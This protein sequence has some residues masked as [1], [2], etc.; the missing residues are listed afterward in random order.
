VGSNSDHELITETINQILEPI[1]RR[2][3][4]VVPSSRDQ[5]QTIKGFQNAL[6][7]PLFE[8][9]TFPLRA[10]D[11]SLNRVFVKPSEEFFRGWAQVQLVKTELLCFVKSGL[12]NGQWT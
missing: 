6:G 3:R 5:Q 8:D 10:V 11:F 1:P 9:Q 12:L 7:S 4:K 2:W